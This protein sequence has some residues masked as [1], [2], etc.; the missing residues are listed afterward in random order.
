[1]L[2]KFFQWITISI[3]YTCKKKREKNNDYLQSIFVALQNNIQITIMYFFFQFE[4][5]GQRKKTDLPSLCWKHS[6]NPN[7][8]R[9][10]G[11]HVQ[12]I[13]YIK[14]VVLLLHKL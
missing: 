3:S 14:K 12:Q 2:R 8:F 6:E 11:H 4:N 7:D 9:R 1:M 5:G 10:V 13:K